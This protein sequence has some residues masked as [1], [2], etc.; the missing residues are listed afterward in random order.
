L[1]VSLIAPG[2]FIV[3]ESLNPALVGCNW[4]IY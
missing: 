1:E 4:L 2:C 3:S